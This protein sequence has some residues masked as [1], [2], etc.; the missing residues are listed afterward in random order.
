MTF[1]PPF[2]AATLIAAST[3]GISSSLLA[4]EAIRPLMNIERYTSPIDIYQ[5]GLGTFTRPISSR[6]AEAQAFFNQGFQMMYSFAKPE[7]IRSF[8]QAWMRDP[9]CAICYWGEAWA[10]GSYLNGPM[11]AEESPHAYAA[12][13]KA[14]SMRDKADDKE[15][16]LIDAMAMRYVENFDATKRM[17]QE[18]TTPALSKRLH[19][20]IPTISTSSRCMPTHCFCLNRVAVRA[21]CTRQRFTVYIRCSRAFWRATCSIPVPAISTCMPPNR[22]SNRGGPNPARNFS[23]ARYPAPVT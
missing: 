17:D 21:T 2:I 4:Q 22:L 10:W 16:A 15:R 13:Q 19:S 14:L 18:R 20:P 1:K 6:S 11:T 23:A 3:L 12:A 9:D 7:A 5:S 8:R